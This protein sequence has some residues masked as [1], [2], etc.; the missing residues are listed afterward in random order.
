MYMTKHKSIICSCSVYLVEDEESRIV[1]VLLD[2][3]ESTMLV[4]DSSGEE[5]GS[6]VGLCTPNLMELIIST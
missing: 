1:T 3:E 6:R 5:V 4:I 2:G